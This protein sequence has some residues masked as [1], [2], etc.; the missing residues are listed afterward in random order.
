D[1]TTPQ[2]WV[3]HLREAVRFHDGIR[4]LQEHGVTTFLEIGPDAVLTAMARDCVVEVEEDDEP[5]AFVATARKNRPAARTLAEALSALWVR[6][7]APDWEKYL[8]GAGASHADLPTYPFQHRHYWLRGDAS[9]TRDTAVAGLGLGSAGHPLLG[10][11]VSLAGAEGLL[12]TGRLSLGTHPWLADHA[13]LGTVVFPGAAVV[14]LGLRAGEKAGCEVLE[15]LTLEAPLVLPASGALQVQVAVGAPDASGRCTFGVYSRAEDDSQEQPWLRNGAGML[16]PGELG[17]AGPDWDLT[18]WPPQG[19]LTEDL[20]GWY[21][22]LAERGF[23]YGPSFQGLRAVW[24]RGTEVFAEVAL[25]PEQEQQAAAFGLHPALLDSA[26]HA[27]ELGVLP[28]TGEPRLPFAWSGVRLHASGASVARVRLTSSAANTVSLLIADETGR[29]LAEVESLALREVGAEQLR[30]ASRTAPHDALFRVQWTPLPTGSDSRAGRWAVIG[31]GGAEFAP[32]DAFADLDAL[33]AAVAAGRPAPDL[34][35]ALLPPQPDA[36]GPGDEGPDAVRAATHQALALTQAWLADARFESARLAVVTRG[37][38]ATTGEEDVRNLPHAAVWGLLR[39]AQTENPD[40]LLLIDLDRADSEGPGSG[41]SAENAL[42]LAGAVASGE[43]Q[44]AV[45]AGGLLAPRL[46]RMGV[47]ADGTGPWGP[48]GTVLIT[49]ATGALGGLIARHLVTEHGVRHLLLTSRRGSAAPGASELAAELTALGAEVTI[50]ACDAADRVALA[51][52]LASIPAE[53]PLTGVVHAAGVLDDGVF[54]SLTPERLDLVLRPKAD[55]AWNLHQATRDLDLTAF[56]LFSSVA[57]IY[58]TA[59]QGSYAAGNALLDALAQH[60]AVRGLPATSL[61]WGLWADGGAMTA[62]LGAADK[63]RLARTG[64]AALDPA[65]GLELFD[66]ALT[67]DASCAVPM[68]L[69]LDALRAAETGIPPLLR[70]L[71]RAPAR[72]AARAAE[73]ATAGSQLLQRLLGRTEAEQSQIL[74]DLVRAEVSAALNYDSTET[75]D[76]RRGFRDLGF[77][78]LTAVELRNRLNTLTGLRLPATLVFDHPNTAAL[79][80]LLRTELGGPVQDASAGEDRTTAGPVGTEDDQIAIVGM[81]CR[82]PGGVGSPEDLWELVAAGGDAISGFPADR[83]WD[84]ENLY[85][86]DPERPGTSYAREG[87]FLHDAGEFDAEF[88]GISPREALAM[89]PQ[90]RLLLETS[91]E[92]FERAGIDP[93]TLRGSRTGVYAGVM[94]HDYASRLA[95]M[96]GDLEGY[97]GTGNTGSVHSG[98]VSYVFGLEGPAVTVDTA[99][100]S[101]LVALH[102]AVQALQAGECT[103]ALA[104]GVTVMSSPGT[105]VEFSRQR[106]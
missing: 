76:E 35:L 78:S 67:V 26:L 45:R 65:Q 57:G 2:Y 10:A 101:S 24:R 31:D 12:L 98:R 16:A 69:D 62:G 23:G 84:L 33:G 14:E 106:G 42:G 81:S 19:A 5:I 74:L 52:L 95:T 97:L 3:N 80:E 88:F 40:R 18:I 29:P 96:P 72:R 60:R 85:D 56:V 37:A 92:T 36:D 4:S 8:G 9:R 22:A 7:T 34:V 27:I 38:V 93:A 82:F 49:G 79:A 66:A 86:P 90:Q 15:E 41:T 70:G 73:G 17:S 63:G 87:G 68:A 1:L 105:F 30:S 13:V 75:V 91:W 20:T 99:C 102:L 54:D 94:Y 61:A 100:S 47:P 46:A 103:L 43:P 32:D 48:E 39:T 83:G 51:G 44:V 77:D 89:D 11:A 64:I 25:P 59:G 55:A 6:G 71:V 104:G 58:G 21:D 50:A 53:Q 28:A